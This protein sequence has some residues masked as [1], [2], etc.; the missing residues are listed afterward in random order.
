MD[1]II[2]NLKKQLNKPQATITTTTQED[3]MLF[4]LIFQQ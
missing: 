4:I 1:K 2:E 3:G